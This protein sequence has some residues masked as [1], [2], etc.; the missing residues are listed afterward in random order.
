MKYFTAE[1][2]GQ[3]HRV[4]ADPSIAVCGR[5]IPDVG[6]GADRGVEDTEGWMRPLRELEA[7]RLHDFRL[8]RG[9]TTSTQ[10]EA[11]TPD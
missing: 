8:A 5:P 11:D 7:P 3:D 10:E 6:D 4:A 1:Q 2:Y 9:L